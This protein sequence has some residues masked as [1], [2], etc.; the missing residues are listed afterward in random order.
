MTGMDASSN[1]HRVSRSRVPEGLKAVFIDSNQGKDVAPPPP[2]A[3][4]TFFNRMFKGLG[5]RR[6][7][8]RS[9]GGESISNDSLSYMVQ[10][11]GDGTD[12]GPEM[13][14][15]YPE[16]LPEEKALPSPIPKV[17][18]LYSGSIESFPEFVEFCLKLTMVFFLVCSIN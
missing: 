15:T 12:A 5:K 11:A 9:K 3:N 6:G 4:K 17:R 18:I 13:K 10:P 2:T 1:S 14:S 7:K 8:S 16:E